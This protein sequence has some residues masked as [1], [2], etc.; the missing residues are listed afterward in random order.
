MKVKEKIIIIHENDEK[1]FGT[2]I[3]ISD[4]GKTFWFQE[5]SGIFENPLGMVHK[6]NVRLKKVSK[7]NW[8]IIF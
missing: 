8:K 3:K 6:V 2:I 7:R 1:N 4:S 5:D